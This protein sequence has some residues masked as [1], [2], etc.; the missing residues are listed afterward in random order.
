MTRFVKRSGE[1][2]GEVEFLRENTLFQFL[3]LASSF[4]TIFSM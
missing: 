2:D 4:R 1:V 3:L